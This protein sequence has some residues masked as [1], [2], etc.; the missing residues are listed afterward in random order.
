LRDLGKEN[1]AMSESDHQ[2]KY[3]KEAVERAGGLAAFSQQRS[4]RRKQGSAAKA[5]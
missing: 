3:S 5:N 2:I 4:A 1:Q